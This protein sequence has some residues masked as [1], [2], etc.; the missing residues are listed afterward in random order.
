MNAEATRRL[1]ADEKRA[2]RAHER[3]TIAWHAMQC[4]ACREKRQ[5]MEDQVSQAVCRFL[6]DEARIQH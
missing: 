3:A 4:P 5:M 2:A 6:G 1:I